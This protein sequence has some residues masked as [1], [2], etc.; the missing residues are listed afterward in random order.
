[1]GSTSRARRNLLVSIGMKPI[2]TRDPG[3][4]ESQKKNERAVDYV[5]RVAR[6]KSEAIQICSNQVLIT[7]DTIV[8]AGSKILHK[9]FDKNVARNHLTMLSGRRH[10][11]FTSFCIK[12]GTI[13]RSATVKTTLK[14]RTMTSQDI[15]QYLFTDEWKGCAGGY[16]IQGRAT[17]FFP[18]IS[19]CFTNIIGL[20][21]PKLINVLDGIK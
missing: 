19:G 15:E 14:M 10:N 3:I 12:K 9:T 5:K 13:I 4:S 18:F 8:V 2:Y 6:K 16:R 21:L 1:M 7:A 17:Q 11:V 20:P